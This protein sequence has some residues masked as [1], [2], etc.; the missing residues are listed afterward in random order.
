MHWWHNNS[1]PLRSLSLYSEENG[2]LEFRCIPQILVVTWNTR[3]AGCGATCTLRFDHTP[4]KEDK[5]LVSVLH[6]VVA[7]VCSSLHRVFDSLFGSTRSSLTAQPRSSE[8]PLQRGAL[9]FSPSSWQTPHCIVQDLNRFHCVRF[10][11]PVLSEALARN[12]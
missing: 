9:I 2:T 1:S 12:C 10:P 8:P 6:I 3:S 5:P 7:A 4:S 11:S